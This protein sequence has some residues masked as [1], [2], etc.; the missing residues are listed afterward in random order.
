MRTFIAIELPVGIKQALAEIQHDLREVQ[1]DVSWPKTE[2]LHLTLKFLGEVEEQRIAGIKNAL[3][4][5]ASATNHFSLYLENID[6]LPNQ[7]QPRVIYSTVKGQLDELSHLQKSIEDKLAPLD[8][9]REERSFKPHITLGR[10]KSAKGMR[11]LIV[12]CL[13]KEFRS[14]AFLVGEVVLMKS[15]L[16]SSGSIYSVIGKAL[17]QD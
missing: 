3:S 7:R 17:L 16:R 1:A 2:N 12:K 9:K 4:E 5:A 15:E 6:L 10:V 8:F 14:E 11:E 13:M